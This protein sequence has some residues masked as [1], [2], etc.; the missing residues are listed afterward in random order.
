LVGEKN[1]RWNGGIR[2]SLGYNYITVPDDHPFIEMAGKVFIH[3]KYRYYIAEHRL[4][5][6]T[7]LNRVLLPWEL[8]HH[9][10]G[11]KDDNRIEN[12]ELIASKAQHLPSIYLQ[13][14]ITELESRVTILEAENE[15]LK[16]LFAEGRDSVN[17]TTEFKAL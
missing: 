9:I 16:A 5:M 2:K 13:R 11:I 17:P 4:A 7:H 12:L 8:V 1:P 10:N 14:R 6:A 3:G 15:L